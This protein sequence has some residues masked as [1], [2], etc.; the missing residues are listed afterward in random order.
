MWRRTI[1]EEKRKRILG[2]ADQG[3]SLR[4][5]ACVTGVAKSTVRKII[6]D[7]RDGRLG[8]LQVDD[9]VV[10]RAD[11]ERALRDRLLLIQAGLDKPISD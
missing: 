4:T 7:S 2:L 1:P 3:R 11:A 8:E 6:V 5:I 10:V 9:F